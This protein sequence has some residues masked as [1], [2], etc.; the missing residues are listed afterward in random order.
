MGLGGTY[1]NP[2]V[3]CVIVHNDEIIGEGFHQRAGEA[4]AEAV[5]IESV[6]DKDLLRESTLYVNL[7][8]CAHLGKTP[9]CSDLIIEHGIPRLV[10]CNTDPFHAVNGKGI[11]Q[12]TTAGI[13]VTTG[14]LE[15]EGTRLNRR[16]F[17]VQKK[18]RPYI[19][20]KWAQTADGNMD[21]ERAPHEQG[22]FVISGE[23]AQWLMH[24]WRSEEHAIMVGTRT[25][26]VDNPRL[27]VRHVSGR[28]PIR[29]VVDRE[30]ELPDSLHLFQGD[31]P[32]IRLLSVDAAGWVQE[33]HAM[34]I[35]SIMVEGGA[36][37]L[38]SFIDADLWDEA[39]IIQSAQWIGHGLRA[40]QL[41]SWPNNQTSVGND[42]I[43][44]HYRE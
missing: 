7:E 25:A 44:T 6:K 11:E 13:A 21:K 35:H 19:I 3:G 15:E 9:P 14:L 26:V 43:F 33:M 36:A 16:F 38:K 34:G 29:F 17:T 28:D 27:N 22:S 31:E 2:L 24:R 37:T 18:Q 23:P 12:L 32:A 8:P 20:L 1:P 4:H 40:P 5:A 42:T 41:N 30:N 39:R 10:I